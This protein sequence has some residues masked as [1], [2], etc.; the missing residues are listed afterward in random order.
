MLRNEF[1][2]GLV[3]ET[4][5]SIAYQLALWE[6]LTL[7]RVLRSKFR[8][9]FRRGRS[10]AYSEMA[11]AIDPWAREIASLPPQEI[12][13]A[14]LEVLAD[15]FEITVPRHIA[16][17]ELDEVC[18]GISFGAVAALR[19]TNKKFDG[20]S[21]NDMVRFLGNRMFDDPSRRLR[22]MPQAEQDAAMQNLVESIWAMPTDQRQAVLKELGA[23]DVVDQD[24]VARFVR[25]AALAGTLGPAFVVAVNIAGFSAYTFA[26]QAVASM[27][28]V[29]GLTLPFGFYTTL[30]SFMALF[31]NP[32]LMVPMLGAFLFWQKWRGDRKFRDS[33]AA[34]IVVGL[35][36][37]SYPKFGAV[38]DPEPLLVE[39]RRR[40]LIRVWNAYVLRYRDFDQP[41]R[42]AAFETLELLNSIYRLPDKRLRNDL[43]QQAATLV[44]EPE[45]GRR[46]RPLWR[47]ILRTV[48]NRDQGHRQ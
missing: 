1:A 48:V 14:L 41:Q 34:S 2:R 11:A 21:I 38:L 37:P 26:T 46:R 7:S 15:H 5:E 18:A 39:L 22:R 10:S 31:A 17:T 3:G 43:L 29:V 40:Q 33:L 23:E 6:Q 42:G 45:P 27:V 19:R 36:V 47:R 8:S 20:S 13:A 24:V 35:I 16:E 25:K 44:Q 4:A 12:R 9:L 28:G 30:T 32:F